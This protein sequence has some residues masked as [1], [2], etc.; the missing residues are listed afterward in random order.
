MPPLGLAALVLGAVAHLSFSGLMWVTLLSLGDCVSSGHDWRCVVA[1]W[2]SAHSFVR[3]FTRVAIATNCLDLLVVC[4]FPHRG[5]R[6]FPFWIRLCFQR[7]I[8]RTVMRTIAQRTH[9]ACRYRHVCVYCLLESLVCACD[10]VVP[11][12]G[13]SGRA[14]THALHVHIIACTFYPRA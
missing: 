5:L 12:A 4:R 8:C 10:D 9:F 14:R 2:R 1:P 11:A 13:A 7:C 3:S 6:R